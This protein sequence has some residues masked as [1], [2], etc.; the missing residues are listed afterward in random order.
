MIWTKFF[1]KIFLINLA[2]RKDRLEQAAEQLNR[3]S[4]PFERVEAI[5]DINGAEGLRLTMVGIFEDAI[6]KG[7]KN[8]A[9]FEDDVDVI[10]E[11]INEVMEVVIKD[12]PE[13]YDICYM[14]CQLCRVPESFHG[15]HLLKA[16]AM[17]ATHAAMYSNKG[18]RQILLNNFTAPIDNAIVA[19][20]QNFG[21]CYAV[22]PILCSQI[23]SHSDIY[24]AEL[25][26]DWK[27]YIEGK[28]WKQ[29][30]AM[31]QN[32]TFNPNAKIYQHGQ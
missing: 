17:F 13:E 22:Y 3:Y 12:L 19:T 28:Y 5:E 29:I 18:M 16:K 6:K 4:I 15:E 2:K 26:L 9:V 25:V 27:P 32:G 31:K 30:E 20:V 8:V 23:V 11:S 10:E 14:G 24:T 7:Y 21:N 1:D